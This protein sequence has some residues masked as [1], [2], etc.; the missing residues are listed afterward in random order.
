MSQLSG[1]RTVYILFSVDVDWLRSALLLFGEQEVNTLAN[2]LSWP[3]VERHVL[4]H[5]PDR[6]RRLWGPFE[7]LAHGTSEFIP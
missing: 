7:H 4:P 5:L 3:S 2:F 1:R 6:F